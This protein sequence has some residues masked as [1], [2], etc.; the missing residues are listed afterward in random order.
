MDILV[1]KMY[2]LTLKMDIL[3]RKRYILT[4]KTYL[5]APKMDTLTPKMY[6]LAPKMGKYSRFEKAQPQWQLCTF[7]LSVVQVFWLWSLYNKLY[8]VL[9]Y[10]KLYKR[11]VWRTDH[12]FERQILL[13]STFVVQYKSTFLIWKS[14]VI[15]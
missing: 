10:K 3:A 2:I 13:F 9:P 15:S 1:P 4:H 7:F 5:W 14:A 12:N 6:I 8:T 11:F